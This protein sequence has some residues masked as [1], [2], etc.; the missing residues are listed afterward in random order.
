ME[1]VDL[2]RHSPKKNI[3]RYSREILLEFQERS[4][5]LSMYTR[6]PHEIV[7]AGLLRE[8]LAPVIE[9]GSDVVIYLFLS[10]SLGYLSFVDP[11][12]ID[13][14]PISQVTSSHQDIRQ[15]QERVKLKPCAFFSQGYCK[16]G[17][18]CTFLH[19]NPYHLGTL[20]FDFLL[21]NPSS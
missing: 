20:I 2:E 19:T 9:N 6:I 5:K 3:V 13:E 8:S 11:I 4:L 15:Q 10:H 17:S 12:P 7:T 18:N 14:S 21:S 1:I 16:Y